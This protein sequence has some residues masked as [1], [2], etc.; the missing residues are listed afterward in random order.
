MATTALHKLSALV[1]PAGQIPS[2]MS[3]SINPGLEAYLLKGSGAISPGFRATM[4]QRPAFSASTV[5]IASALTA[6][7]SGFYAF[8]AAT[9]LYLAKLI[10]GGGLAGTLAHAQLQGSKGCII[11]RRLRAQQGREATLDFDGYFLSSDGLAAPW[12]YTGS[13]SLPVIAPGV[14]A[15]TL[16]PAKI[17]A[18]A[19]G[20]L[21][22]FELDF[23]YREIVHASEG[24]VFPDFACYEEYHPTLTLQTADPTLINALTVG[25]VAQSSAVGETPSV[26]YLRKLAAAGRVAAATAQHIKLSMT[27]GFFEPREIG[28]NDSGQTV[29]EIGAIPVI[30]GVN[31]IMVVN[32]ASAIT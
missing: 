26:F 5:A 16:G 9:T 4:T 21:E 6:F 28:E 19:L 20:A 31:P 18:S 10:S 25:G 22:G 14:E 24:A 27:A 23:G 8:S 15:F 1:T 32:L 30:D 13:V 3:R 12:A 11:P 29:F 17:N 2:L 7:G